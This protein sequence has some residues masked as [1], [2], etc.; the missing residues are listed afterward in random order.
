MNLSQCKCTLQSSRT[1]LR[2][3][4]CGHFSNEVGCLYCVN[5]HEDNAMILAARHGHVDL[6]E[7]LYKQHGCLL[8]V[9]NCDGKRPL[10]EAA[11]NG[12]VN[13]AQYLI[14]QGA[15]IDSLKRADWS[16]SE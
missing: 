4:Q 13:C 5:K 2:Q 12:H 15:E 6:L 16:D 14:E 11:Q 8:E 7:I 3:I 1:F 10:H 9:S